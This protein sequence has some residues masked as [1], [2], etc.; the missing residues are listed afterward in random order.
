MSD[1]RPRPAY[2]EYATPEEVA[3]ITGRPVRPEVAAEPAPLPPPDPAE[4]RHA[5]PPVAAER[6]KVVP[7]WDRG[8]TI[9]LLFAGL[10]Y[11]ILAIP[12]FLQFD[13]G[14]RT[15]LGLDELRDAGTYRAVGIATLV[16]HVLVLAGA[17]Y[18][19][20]RRVTAGRRAFWV[21]LVGAAIVNILPA[22]VLASVMMQDPAIVSRIMGG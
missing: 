9:G 22:I 1:A 10:F 7:A 3:A 8:L 15:Q 13:V 5:P 2:G 6:V 16:I 11:L 4:L 19:S 20:F 14:L 18:W 12:G 17:A 21:P